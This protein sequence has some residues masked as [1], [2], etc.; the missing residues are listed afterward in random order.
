[1]ASH[2]IRIRVAEGTIEAA[3][4]TPDGSH[5]LVDLTYQ[6]LGLS[7][8]AAEMGERAA[9]RRGASISCRAGCGAC[10]R[11][12]VPV[13]PP[14]AVLIQEI[15]DSMDGTRRR[16]LKER[17]AKAV[18]RL[19]ETGLLARL[20]D[21]ANPLLHKAEEDYFLQRIPCPFLEN[22][23]CSIY[24]VRPSRCR[25][26]LVFTP[27]ELCADPFRNK[28]GRLPISM[29][30]NEA[31][32]WL[33]ASMTGERPR[34][35]PLVLSFKWT[36]ENQET[37]TLRADPRQMIEELCGHIENIARNVEREALRKSRRFRKAKKKKHKTQ[38]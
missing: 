31:L 23:S 25:E 22:E 17:F 5:R 19:K 24:E 20:E 33:W 18:D 26:Y 10:C 32:A 8:V 2:P 11:Q 34:Y 3:V 27:P 7:S 14:E 16:A 6:V 15:V 30:L 37:R 13:S 28:I 38:R 4:E 21:P 29:H 36:G 35:V 9:G 12:L 1:M